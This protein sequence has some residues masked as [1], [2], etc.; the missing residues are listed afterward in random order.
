MKKIV[1]I[2]KVIHSDYCTFVARVFQYVSSLYFVQAVV[3]CVPYEA[4]DDD[5]DSCHCMLC[6]GMVSVIQILQWVVFVAFA[7]SSG[8]G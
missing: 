6:Y 1:A 3:L 4:K 5:G 7:S 2:E 8:C